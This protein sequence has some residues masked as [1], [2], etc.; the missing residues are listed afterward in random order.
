[1]INFLIKTLITA[2]AILVA[3]F[4]LKGHGIT[5]EGGSLT[6]IIIALVLGLLNSFVKPLLVILTIPITIFTLGLFLLVIN[7]LIIKWTS[8][9]V[10][11]FKVDGWWPALF[12]SLI[13][14]FVSSVIEKLISNNPKANSNN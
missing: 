10:S 3:A 1:M 13:V 8:G 6:V 2:V 7:V 14:S 5:I 9:L 4:L 11:E 12:F